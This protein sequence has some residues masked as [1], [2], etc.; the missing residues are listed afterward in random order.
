MNEL[1]SITNRIAVSTIESK[2][3]LLVI[4]FFD[5]KLFRA[6]LHQ[7]EAAKIN[8]VNHFRNHLGVQVAVLPPG[9]ELQIIQHRRNKFWYVLSGQR[10][11]DRI[12][13]RALAM[14]E[15]K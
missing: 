7:D 15:K 4:R 14:Y 5:G 8:F 2:R 12:I 9:M 1:K 3:D 6:W 13:K 11:T 10:S